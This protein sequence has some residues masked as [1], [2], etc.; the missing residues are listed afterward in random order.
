[1]TSVIAKM[2]I[3]ET[4][5]DKSYVDHSS[6]AAGRCDHPRSILSGSAY[7]FWLQPPAYQCH[8]LMQHRVVGSTGIAEL[9]LHRSPVGRVFE[10]ASFE[11]AM[12]STESS[13]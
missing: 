9:C 13:C 2:A 10:Q 7:Y 5:I 3:R 1:M 8:T 11:V 12:T 4:H 6:S